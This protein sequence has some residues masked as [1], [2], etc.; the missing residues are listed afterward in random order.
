MT[1]HTFKLYK[2][3]EVCSLEQVAKL[4]LTYVINFTVALVS[5]FFCLVFFFN[6]GI[7]MIENCIK[8][9]FFYFSGSYSHQCKNDD[10]K[11]YLY[12][13][14]QLFKAFKKVRLSTDLKHYG[15]F[16][17]VKCSGLKSCFT[18]IHP[19]SVPLLCAGSWQIPSQSQQ[20]L[21]RAGYCTA[22]EGQMLFLLEGNETL[23]TYWTTSDCHR[24]NKE[25]CMGGKLLQHGFWH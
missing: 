25:K 17:P 16:N 7:K 20:A 23:S 13:F 21:V 2:S 5:C 3:N 18:S 4:W 15:T 9:C 11:S 12:Y 10:P 22:Q 19:L 24:G 8:Q 14:N 6:T 1:H